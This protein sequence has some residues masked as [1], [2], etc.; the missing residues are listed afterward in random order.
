MPEETI[1]GSAVSVTSPDYSCDTIL[2]Q[3]RQASLPVIARIEKDVVILD[4]RT[5]RKGDDL[6]IENAFLEMLG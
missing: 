3:L 1:A 5:L 2:S 6:G 4:V